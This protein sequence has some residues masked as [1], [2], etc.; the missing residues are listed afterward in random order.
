[1][2]IAAA[3]PGLVPRAGSGSRVP[4]HAIAPAIR[5]TASHIL[6]DPAKL[7]HVPY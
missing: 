4:I 6:A 2:A 7:T 3:L 1:M 5:P